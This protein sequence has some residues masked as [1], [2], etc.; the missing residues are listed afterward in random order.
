MRGTRVICLCTFV[1]VAG[2][3]PAAAQYDYAPTAGQWSGSA[4][5]SWEGAVTEMQKRGPGADMF[6]P[7]WAGRFIVADP[8]FRMS[9]RTALRRGYRTPAYGYY[10]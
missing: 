4:H 8:G 6:G 1:L 7:D 5:A 9:Q 3:A 2:I 10:R